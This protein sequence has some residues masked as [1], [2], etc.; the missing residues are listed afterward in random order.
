[1]S[2][3]KL[4]VEGSDLLSSQMMN[5]WR[6]VGDRSIRFENMEAF[7]DERDP[8]G[9][10][11]VTY[12]KDGPR[13]AKN[14]LN[15]GPV[16]QEQIQRLWERVIEKKITSRHLQD[17]MERKNP[18]RHKLRF[19]N[20]VRRERLELQ[21]FQD[22]SSLMDA[23]KKKGWEIDREA[24]YI[25]KRIAYNPLDNRG[26]ARL[27]R[28]TCDDM[29]MDDGGTLFESIYPRAERFGLGLCLPTMALH[30]C[31]RKK[32]VV[33]NHDTLHIGMKPLPGPNGKP[34]VLQLRRN[35]EYLLVEAMV[36][37][38]NTWWKHSD[39]EWLFL[40]S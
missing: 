38:E 24:A 13:T 26:K 14:R 12:Y 19:E 34:M 37:D 15:D 29:G 18:F 21:E 2:N 10:H 27:I 9:V 4:V 20:G 11:L 28:A 16:S 3:Q 22:M 39:L 5:F 23:V 35:D 17:F 30:L 36:A 7:L 1:M 33:E 8:F 6:Q 40:E 32:V 31:L 25:L